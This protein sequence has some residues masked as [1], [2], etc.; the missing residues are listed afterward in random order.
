MATLAQASKSTSGAL[1]AISDTITGVDRKRKLAKQIAEDRIAPL[2]RRMLLAN[3]NTAGVKTRTGELRKALAA[4][5]VTVS[6]GSKP[7][8]SIKMPRGREKVYGDKSDFYEASAAVNYGAV[9]GLNESSN[10]RKAKLKR[11]ALKAKEGKSAISDGR[12]LSGARETESGGKAFAG[13]I[14]VT[15]PKG[16]WE[17]TGAQQRE[18]GEV[19]MSVLVNTVFGR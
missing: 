12:I 8:I 19:A 3:L 1:S 17:L 7:K 6:F 15:T 4:V 11:K 9:R 2:V 13:G 5:T 18:I 14:V 16:Y 10:K